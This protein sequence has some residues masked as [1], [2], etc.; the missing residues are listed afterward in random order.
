MQTPSIIGLIGCG[1]ISTSYFR[2]SKLFDNIRIDYCA[3]LFPEAALKTAQE[4]GIQAQSIEQLLQNSNVDIILN[5]TTPQSHCSV[6]LAALNAGKHVYCEK[7]FGLEL[8][9]AKQVLDRA[10]ELNLYVG[11]APDTF[12]GAGL[13]T[14]RKIVDDGWLGKVTAGSANMSCHGHESWH[15]NP[16]FYYQKGAGP[17]YDMGPYYI[18]ALVNILGPVASV[19]AM[20]NRSSEQRI[21]SCEEQRGKVLDVEVDTHVCALLKF[22]SGTLINFSMSFDTWATHTAPIEL[23]GQLGSLKVNDPNMFDGDIQLFSQHNPQWQSIPYSH[24]N[25]Q[26]MRSVGLADMASAIRKNRPARASGKLAYHVLEVMDCI[27]RSCIS[28]ETH[29]IT[30][31][32]S[33]TPPLPCELLD[34]Q[35]D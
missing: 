9:E 12:L 11:C 4:H 30:S 15:P 10:N 24:A 29:S 14:C 32:C 16:S 6:N 31:T 25:Q 18:T 7:P 3:D 8:A 35:I 26:D 2:A 5:L 21:A 17:L 13:Q 1:N 27:N 33:R 23:H 20:S 22:E 34:G 28:T 19:T